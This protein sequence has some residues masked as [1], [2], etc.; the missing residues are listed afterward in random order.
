MLAQDQFS[1]QFVGGTVYQG[2]L[3]ALS[4]HRWHSPVS[5]KIVKAYVQDGT[6]FSQPYIA[7]H[8]AK[9]FNS[10]QAYLA[11]VATR[12]IIFINADNPAIGLMCFL[13]VGMAEVG[14]C[15]ITVKHGQ[16]VKKGDQLGM[17]HFGGS[18][19]C[20]LFRKGVHLSGFPNTSRRDNLP[21]RSQLAVVGKNESGHKKGKRIPWFKDARSTT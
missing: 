18:S 2:L 1:D 14:T 11:A 9:K 20:L 4:Y 17:F 5:G 10:S 15:E 16:H 8:Q 7:R 6:Y 12:T 19:H 13:A 3:S 21:V